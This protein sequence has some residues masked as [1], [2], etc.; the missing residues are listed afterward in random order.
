MPLRL[1]ARW[2]ARIGGLGLLL[3]LEACIVHDT[4][5]VNSG[6][7][8]AYGYG[9]MRGNATATA[10]VS[11]GEPAPYTVSGMPPEPL[12]EQMSDSP[13]DGSVWI[14][15]YWHWNGYEWVWVNGRWEREQPGYVYVEPNYDYQGEQ[16]VYTPGYWSQPER[17]PRGWNVRD[18]RDGRPRRVA[19]PVNNVGARPP[20][21]GTRNPV[22]RAPVAN[23][24]GGTGV[25]IPP[26]GPARPQRPP[27]Y[28]PS[29]GRTWRPPPPPGPVIGRG[30]GPGPGIGTNP[31][32]AGGGAIEPPRANPASGGR[33]WN[34]PPATSPS[35]G[36]IYVN[37]AGPGG[38]GVGRPPPPVMGRPIYVNPAGPSPGGTLRP[39]PPAQPGGPIWVNPSGPSAPPP[40]PVN[41]G[42]GGAVYRPPAPHNGG[43]RPG[44]SAP[45][46]PPVAAPAPGP[47]TSNPRRPQ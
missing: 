4:A 20:I 21:R 7:N 23:P 34:P 1:R 30:G 24:G 38:G 43:A 9:G 12:Y 41:N 6:Y 32:P 17:V 8:E 44:P 25:Y 27:Y 10:S 31:Q 47:R 29:G 5:P 35:G 28:D 15:G 42:G 22:G 3:G 16:Y 13:G 40:P 45:P 33:T 2:I 18:H 36:P 37:P 39:P 14:D 26:G 19:P 11:V 46:P